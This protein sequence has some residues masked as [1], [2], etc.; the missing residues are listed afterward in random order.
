[1]EAEGG[2]A[3]VIQRPPVSERR[4][5]Q[6]EGAD[7]VGLDERIRA[8]DRAIDMAFGGKVHDHVGLRIGEE[9]AHRRRIDDVGFDKAI[10]GI[11]GDRGER[12]KIA[13][14]GQLVDDDDAVRRLGDQV[15]NHRRAD[16]AGSSRD[17]EDLAV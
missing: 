8:V 10:A 5:K 4:L 12:G 6:R 7:E 9:P 2:P 3:L 16:E 15:S 14:I 13:G 11:P 17:D 1:M